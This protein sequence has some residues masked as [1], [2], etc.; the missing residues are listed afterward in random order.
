MDMKEV[1]AVLAIIKESKKLTVGLK[2]SIG[3]PSPESRMIEHGI[4]PYLNRRQRAMAI[5]LYLV[6]IR[7]LWTKSTWQ[8]MI[9]FW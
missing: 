3:S 4:V 9:R 7:V 2:F 5:R 8:K 1:Q 6:A